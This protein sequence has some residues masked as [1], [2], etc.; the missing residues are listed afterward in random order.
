MASNID[1]NKE[2]LDNIDLQDDENYSDEH[3]KRTNKDKNLKSKFFFA[4]IKMK[5][6]FFDPCLNLMLV[7]SFFF[8][9]Q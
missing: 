6:K 8:N 7:A 9:P 1:D 5:N 3:G 2:I 4:C